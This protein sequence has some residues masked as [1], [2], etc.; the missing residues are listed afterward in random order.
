MDEFY[1]AMNAVHPS[2]RRIGADEITY[3]LHVILRYELERDY[4]SGKIGTEDLN[5]AW[6]DKYKKYLGV[7]PEN[8]TEGIL[9]DMHW[10]GDYIGYFQSYAL[11]N[12]YD[13]QIRKALLSEIPDLYEQIRHGEFDRLNKWMKEHIWQYGC[14]YT[15][16]EML[17]RLTGKTLDAVPFL[18]YMKEKYADLYGI[19]I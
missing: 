8:D 16:G 6:N 12:I 3:S 2:L 13:G 10:A 14:C 7:C 4:F 15:S 19:H 18:D 5:I 11:G 17:K 9:Q 1:R